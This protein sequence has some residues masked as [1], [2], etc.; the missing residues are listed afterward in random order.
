MKRLFKIGSIARISLGIISLILSLVLASDFFF[1]LLPTKQQQQAESRNFGT[2][3]IATQVSTLLDNGDL[4]GLQNMFDR[5]TSNSSGIQ[6][7]GIRQAD[8]TLVVASRDHAL[9]WRSATAGMSAPTHVVVPLFIGKT[10]WG[11]IELMFA[12]SSSHKML[13][14]FLQPEIALLTLLSTLGFAI[15]YFYLRRALHNLDPGHSVPQRVRVAFDTL[16]EA[17]LITNIKGQI[18]LGNSTFQK[19]DS[20]SLDQIEG[21]SIEKLDWLIAAL[22]KSG[23]TDEYPWHSVLRSNQAMQGKNLKVTMPDGSCRYLIMNCAAIND[24]S[25][26]ARG[27]LITLDDVTELSE[28]TAKLQHTLK[29][30]EFSRDQIQQQNEELQKHAHYDYLTGCLNRRAFFEKADLLLQNAITANLPLFCIMADIDHFKFFNDQYG[31]PVGDLVIQTVAAALR[32]SLRI[33]DILCRYGGEEFCILLV[34]ADEATGIKIAERIRAEIQAE[35]GKGVRT[36]KGLQ[37]TA[38]VGV[39][40]A[41]DSTGYPS[42]PQLIEQADQGLYVAKNSGRNRV[43]YAN[44]TIISGGDPPPQRSELVNVDT[45]SEAAPT[46]LLAILNDSTAHS[47]T[48]KHE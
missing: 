39:A 35:C 19:M 18:M 25:G 2:H 34:N 7:I 22:S 21:R 11:D 42:L 26:V 8:S 47:A 29:D 23:P 28:A 16:S 40:L 31:H 9:R 38:S 45:V 10:R 3:V 43:A 6:S 13:E 5:L 37:I 20:G 4:A 15:V 44:G 24:G 46:N 14:W 30:L 48:L 1:D 41:V 17:V 27:C 36:V 32:S 33:G 12:D